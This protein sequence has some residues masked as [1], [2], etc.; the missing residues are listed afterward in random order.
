[1]RV[2]ITGHLGKAILREFLGED[3]SKGR[4]GAGGSGRTPDLFRSERLA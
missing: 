4:P 1:M 2:I 3:P